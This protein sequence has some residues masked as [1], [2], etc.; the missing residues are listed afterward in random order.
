MGVVL[1]N[2]LELVQTSILVLLTLKLNNI[3]FL[4]RI[5]TGAI[6]STL[7]NPWSTS[8]CCL[9]SLEWCA[10]SFK[11][12]CR[13]N[14]QTLVRLKTGVLVYLQVRYMKCKQTIQQ[15]KKRKWQLL[16]GELHV[17]NQLALNTKVKTETPRLHK[18]GIAPN[19]LLLPQAFF[20]SFLVS[21]RFWQYTPAVVQAVW[22]A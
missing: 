4:G 14:M 7:N 8:M 15:T 22:S 1:C 10:S 11:F 9:D 12:W 2:Q 21:G 17:K 5:H 19:W 18:F 20:F 6:W 16:V 13:P 3:Y